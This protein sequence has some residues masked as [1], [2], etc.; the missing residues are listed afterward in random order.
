MSEIKLIIGLGNPG[1]SFYYHR[2][3]IGFRVLDALADKQG[4]AWQ[5][6]DNYEVAQVATTHGSV[7]LIKPLTY[8]N[9][10]GSVLPAF[11]K[12]GIKAEN[13]VVVHDELE[14]P[15]G[16]V[17]VKQGGSARGHN[18]LKSIITHVGDNFYRVRVGVS[19]PENRD[20]VP[21]YVLSNFPE[22]ADKVD[23]VIALAVGE[24]EALLA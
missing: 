23:A 22:P 7:Y 4:I 11:T 20:D 8:M 18:G 21:D 9:S 19:R 2:H 16:K 12:K 15:F 3:S 24:L 1:Q 13:I 17:T 6:K 5:K 10:S 14:I